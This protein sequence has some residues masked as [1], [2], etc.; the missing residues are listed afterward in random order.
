MVGIGAPFAVSCRRLRGARWRVLYG[1]ELLG[2][3][4]T[5]VR[6]APRE[7]VGGRRAGERAEVAVEVRLVVVAAVLGDLGEARAVVLLQPGERMLEAEHASERLRCHAEVLAELERQ[8]ARAASHLAC[9][10][11]DGDAAVRRAQPLPRPHQ[12]GRRWGGALE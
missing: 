9:E 12:A 1:S 6:Q 2:C 4:T 5:A 10:R 7:V 8:V 11:P 3:H